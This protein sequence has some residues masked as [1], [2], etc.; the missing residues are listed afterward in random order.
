MR[1]DNRT[2]DLERA[3]LVL[4]GAVQV[5]LIASITLITVALP[6]IQRDLGAD[7]S[8]LVLVTSAIRLATAMASRSPFGGCR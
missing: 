3:A 4:L 7:P 2:I 1:P 6:G 8:D 5:T